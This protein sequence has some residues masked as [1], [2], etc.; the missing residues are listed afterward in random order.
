MKELKHEVPLH[1]QEPF[2]RDFGKWQPGAEDYVTDL[3]AGGE[4][5]A[6]SSQKTFSVRR[7]TPADAA[8][9]LECLRAA[10]EPYRELYTPAAFADTVLSPD[11][12]G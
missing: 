6:M 2:R 3:A 7:A 9:N 4:E 8:S 1:Y 5:R 12:I 11:T 10:F